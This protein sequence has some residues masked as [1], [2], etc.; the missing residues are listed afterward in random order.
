MSSWCF[1]QWV[2]YFLWNFS[3][4]PI[5]FA[6]YPTRLGRAFRYCQEYF[7][8]H[9]IKRGPWT[10]AMHMVLNLLYWPSGIPFGT[11]QCI[12]SWQDTWRP[13]KPFISAFLRSKLNKVFWFVLTLLTDEWIALLLDLMNFR[14]YR[15]TFAIKECVLGNGLLDNVITLYIHISWHPPRRNFLVNFKWLKIKFLFE[16]NRF[17]TKKLRYALMTYDV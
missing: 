5:S 11:S 8:Q 9:V 2:W 15:K 17:K 12:Y 14:A 10:T 13:M 16:E 6:I 4:H 1:F 7:S 3:C